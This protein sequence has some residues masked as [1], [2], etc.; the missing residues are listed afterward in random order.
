MDIGGEDRR[1]PRLCSE[2]ARKRS[3]KV[4]IPSSMQPSVLVT[5]Q[6]DRAATGRGTHS[7]TPL[8][9]FTV[10]SPSPRKVKYGDECR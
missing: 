2:A 1:Y 8:F 4:R 10:R 3:T 7:L 9:S 5:G 6:T